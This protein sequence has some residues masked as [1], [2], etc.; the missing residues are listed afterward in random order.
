MIHEVICAQADRGF[1]KGTSGFC[2]VAVTDGTPL[3]HIQLLADIAKRQVEKAPKESPFSQQMFCHFPITL[4]S[5][6]YHL[7]SRGFHNRHES[8][9]AKSWT[10]HQFLVENVKTLSAGPAWLL[11]ND[12]I[13]IEQWDSDPQ[14]LKP[15]E[16]EGRMLSPRICESWSKV[17]GD[18]GWA[19]TALEAWQKSKAFGLVVQPDT[20]PTIVVDMLVEAQSLME[21]MLRWQVPMAISSWS[22]T[23]IQS[24]IWTAYTSGS[25]QA[26][27]ASRESGWIVVDVT[28]KL[29]LAANAFSE[30]ARSGTWAHLEGPKSAATQSPNRAQRTPTSPIYAAANSAPAAPAT[31][32]AM[33]PLR[34]LRA[35]H[36]GRRLPAIRWGTLTVVCFLLAL[37]GV[38]IW[39]GPSLVQ[40]AVAAVS[41][42]V[43][44]NST[45]PV[46]RDPTTQGNAIAETTPPVVGTE[47][48]ATDSVA[49]A[50]TNKRSAPAATASA[51]LLSAES[52]QRLL[53]QIAAEN[54][55]SKIPS[56]ETQDYQSFMTIKAP[57]VTLGR[58]GVGL[59]T[60]HRFIDLTEQS[61]FNNQDKTYSIPINNLHDGST[62]T[63]DFR[64]DPAGTEQ[65][66]TSTCHWRWGGPPSEEL[67]RDLQ[68]GSLLIW[69]RDR[70]SVHVAIPFSE[71]NKSKPF[72]LLDG[73]LE[74][75]VFRPH[76]ADAWSNAEVASAVRWSPQ[77]QRFTA[78]GDTP[79]SAST[80][81]WISPQSAGNSTNHFLL[82]ET[83]LETALAATIESQ[84]PLTDE[85]KAMISELVHAAMPIEVEIHLE[86]PLP[87]KPN[88]TDLVSAVR[89]IVF[90]RAADGSKN[91]I[92][93]QRP[94]QESEK[95]KR[96]EF[97]N[98]IEK[99]IA[100][101]LLTNVELPN[102]KPPEL[103]KGFNTY[104][105]SLKRWE[106]KV[107]AQFVQELYS[108][109]VA[110]IEREVHYRVIRVTK[111]DMP[112]GKVDVEVV[113]TVSE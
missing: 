43:N 52:A 26:V 62:L 18:S 41:G 75:V 99:R 71:A 4:Q 101:W 73:L 21:P 9:G 100:A 50:S 74:G 13:W 72:S 56:A 31:A 33:N 87:V 111:L 55:V 29:E 85:I 102:S 34:P 95:P 11:S 105:G 59:A 60:T 76:C 92:I 19:G 36:R 47:S 107:K 44:S 58:F 67:A 28:R 61:R 15:R 89:W 54:P 109:L 82:N 48:N 79:E 113:A 64:I 40:Q 27:Q 25:I 66:Q 2:P 86:P 70:P 110:I 38:A 68:V 3:S 81:L 84:Q 69:W 30:V 57:A 90:M 46:A 108:A 16:I 77:A 98:E 104:L 63:V 8:N 20:K 80:D 106:E 24:R 93:V 5:K 35:R 51:P 88:S 53:D 65:E 103:G 78:S 32:A 7:I 17:T 96:S 1:F 23:K 22:P 83:A 6:V 14:L 94:A 49:A 39:K 112:T 37:T 91:S 45:S 12:A 10:I 42:M 97:R